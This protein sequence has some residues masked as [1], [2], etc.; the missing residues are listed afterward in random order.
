MTRDA[1][2]ERFYTIRDL[3]DQ[4]GVTARTLRFYEDRGLLAPQRDGARRLY[5][6]IDRARLQ[7][8]LRGKRVG[9]SLDEIGEMLDIAQ[10]RG[11]S[12]EALQSAEERFAVRIGVLKAQRDDID[13]AIRDLE[14]GRAWLCAMRQGSEPG[15]ALRRRAAAFE[16]LAQGWLY[17]EEEDDEGEGAP[18]H[19]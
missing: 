6:E 17:N 9:F 1:T 11:G 8:I 5:S 15:E 10:Y 19:A 12:D 3:I 16:A 18:Y 4:F 7:L 13:L 14:V 2:F